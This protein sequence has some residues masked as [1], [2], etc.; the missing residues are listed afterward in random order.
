MPVRESH[1]KEQQAGS[2]SWEWSLIANKKMVTSVLQSQGTEFC[3]QS[4]RKETDIPLEPPERNT[5]LLT[6]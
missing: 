1:G 3:Q 2:R 6:S 5:A 4:L